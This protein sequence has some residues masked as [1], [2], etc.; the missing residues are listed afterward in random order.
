MF[1]QWSAH[2]EEEHEPGLFFAGIRRRGLKQLLC[3]LGAIHVT[4]L[5]LPRAQ[6]AHEFVYVLEH[7]AAAK[8]SSRKS[9][10]G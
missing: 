6:T 4:K 8:N 5:P 2:Q 7:E 3:G 9:T 10:C 1:I